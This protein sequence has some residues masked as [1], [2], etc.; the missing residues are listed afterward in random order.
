METRPLLL[1]HRGARGKKSIAENTLTA[2]DFAHACG[3]DGFEFDVRLTADGQ[4][5]VCHDPRI[6]GLE[7]GTSPARHLC[8]PLLREV[9]IR[10]RRSA[11]LDIELKI[12]GLEAITVQLLQKHRP[13]KGFV[14]SSFLPGVL[15]RTRVLDPAIPLGLICET[16]AELRRGPQMPAEY[17]MVHHKLLRKDLIQKIKDANKKVFVWTVNVPDRMK[18]FALWGVDGI[19]SDDP[20]RL[21]K[22]LG[23]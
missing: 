15:E 2:F 5:V 21:M 14:I 23:G 3:C 18:R 20:D 12:P 19:I 4:A 6:R 1:G 11:F 8:L 16:S 22:T 7:I 17:V 9:L 13:T 10:Y